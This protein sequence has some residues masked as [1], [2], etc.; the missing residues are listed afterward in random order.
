MSLQRLGIILCSLLFLRQFCRLYL[1]STTLSPLIISMV[2]TFTGA[3]PTPY[4]NYNLPLSSLPLSIL[5]TLSPHCGQKQSFPVQVR[6]NHSAND[7]SLHQNKVPY[8]CESF[9]GP[10]QLIANL[11]LPGCLWVLHWSHHHCS[12]LPDRLSGEASI[13]HPLSASWLADPPAPLWSWLSIS[14]KATFHHHSYYCFLFLS[15]F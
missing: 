6:L 15:I 4:D 14:R 10:S 2:T 3:S 13:V 9:Q 7:I 8:L 1:L 5:P 12:W 11:P